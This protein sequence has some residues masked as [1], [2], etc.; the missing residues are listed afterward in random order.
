MSELYARKIRNG[1]ANPQTG[2][3]WL[4]EDVP[5]M[6]RLEVEEILAYRQALRDIPEQ[7]GFP[8]EVVWPKL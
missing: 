8:Y 1:E 5:E 7:T 6:W 2:K 4:A 3:E